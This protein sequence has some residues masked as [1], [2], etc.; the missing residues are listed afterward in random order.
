MLKLRQFLA[1]ARHRLI[2]LAWCVPFSWMLS[3]L[4]YLSHAFYIHLGF[5]SVLHFVLHCFAAD[6][7]FLGE[8]FVA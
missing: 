8:G 5:P 2:T 3:H 7:H 6:K 1:D 4:P